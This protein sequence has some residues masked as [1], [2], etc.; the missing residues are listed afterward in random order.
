MGS[1]VGPGSGFGLAPDLGY[2]EYSLVGEKKPLRDIE[3]LAYA[4]ASRTSMTTDLQLLTKQELLSQ[5]KEWGQVTWD[6]AANAKTA[7]QRTAEM[8]QLIAA[9]REYQF[10]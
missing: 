4:K 10:G 2:R 1:R 6:S 3:T 9:T 7:D 5:A 8:L